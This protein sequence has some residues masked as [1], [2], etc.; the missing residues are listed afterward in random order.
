MFHST[1]TSDRCTTQSS[2][3]ISIIDSHLERDYHRRHP[4]HLQEQH[5]V[6]NHVQVIRFSTPQRGGAFT[7]ARTNVSFPLRVPNGQGLGDGFGLRVGRGDRGPYDHNLA[8]DKRIEDCLHPRNTFTFIEF[9]GV[10]TSGMYSKP[11][12][13]SSS[14]V[15]ED[16]PLSLSSRKHALP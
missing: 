5:H 12:P 7:R 11:G 13:T 10:P 1:A 15:L 9:L 3:P 8:R 14:V 2:A 16:P 6:E 4:G